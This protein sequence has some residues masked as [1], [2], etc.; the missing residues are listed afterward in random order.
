MSCLAFASY[1]ASAIFLTPF[2]VRHLGNSAYGLIPL[3]G[4]FTQYSA[5]ICK[6]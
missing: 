1:S 2:L 5:I 3:A 4:L 6:S